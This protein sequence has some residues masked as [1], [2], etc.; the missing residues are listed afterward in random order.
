MLPLPVKGKSVFSRQRV[1]VKATWFSPL[2][3]EQLEESLGQTLQNE[4]GSGMEGGDTCSW[5]C[6]ASE[7]KPWVLRGAPALL[8]FSREKDHVSC[9]CC[10]KRPG[11]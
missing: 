4:V 2:N 3:Q 1:Q 10:S 7:A 8:T 11:S 6:P 9:G 5:R